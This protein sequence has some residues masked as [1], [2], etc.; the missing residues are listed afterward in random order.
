MQF[1]RA[2]PGQ[3]VEK[4]S[5]D[6]LGQIAKLPGKL[7]PMP[8][9]PAQESRVAGVLPS[10]HVQDDPPVDGRRPGAAHQRREA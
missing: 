2:V 10:F 9:P 8:D 5:G 3:P 6:L 4:P 1:R 7:A